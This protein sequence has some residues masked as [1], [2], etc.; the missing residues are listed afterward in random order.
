VE[1]ATHLVDLARLLAGEA[2]P[3][4]ATADH[5]PDPQVPGLTAAV[6]STALLRFAS[7][8]TGTLTASCTLAGPSTAE[9]KLIADGLAITVRQD[10]VLYEEPAPRGVRSRYV[11]TVND[12]FRDEDRAFF[13][14]IRHGD[15]TRLFS[16]YEDALQTHR[17]TC[18]IRAKA[19]AG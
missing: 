7:G 10:G 15:P 3:L 18:A 4:A 2:E 8:A 13:D 6:T 14:A 12:P 16:T 11:K 19:A 1:Q 17:L 9:L 5:D